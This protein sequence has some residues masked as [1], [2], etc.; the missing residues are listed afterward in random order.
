MTLRSCTRENEVKEL[1]AR[2]QYP[3]ACTPEL[4]AHVTSCHSCSDLVLIT[5]AFQSA[6]VNTAAV[7]NLPSPGLLWWRAQLRRRNAAVE[8]ISK[9]ILGAQVFALSVSVLFAVGLVA[10]QA[11]YGL[12]WLSWFEGVSWPSQLHQA[13]ALHLDALFPAALLNSTASL[14]VLVPIL[15]TLVL[16]GGVAVYFA[17]EKNSENDPR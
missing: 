15:A 9:P 10:T 2:G 8:R 3:Q 12:H 11:T 1:L 5:R 4:R 14:L 7:A 13:P 6:R 16:L 17:S